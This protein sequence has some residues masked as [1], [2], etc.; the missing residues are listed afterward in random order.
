VNL[1]PRLRNRLGGFRRLAGV[2]TSATLLA[3]LA[4]SSFAAATI[5]IINIDGPGEGFNDATA[6]APVGGNPGVTIGQQRLLCF[7]Q[8]ATIWGATLTSSVTIQI[9]AA[10]N[11][12][13]CTATSAVLGSAGPRFVEFGAPGLEF[14][15]VWYHEALACKEAGVD[16]T[17]AGD[18]G[19]PPGDDGSDINA[20]FNSNLGN[21]GCLTGSGWY[22]GFD[23]NEGAK[24]DLLAV[25]EHEF[26]HGLGFSTVTSGTTGNYLN[27]P[28]ALPALWDKYLFDE[29]TGLHWD[30]NTAAQR[31]ASA[32]NTGNLTWDGPSVTTS[33]GTFLAHSP[34]LVVPYAPGTVVVNTAAFG[35]ALTIAGVT[36][37][38]VVVVD[39]VAPTG[40]GCDTPF[41]NA[42]A[43]AGKIAVIDRGTCTFV[44]KVKNA[45]DAGA[46]GCI[47]VNNAAGAL[48]P[49]GADPTITIPTVGITLADGN[50]LKAAITGGPTTVTMRLNPTLL[51]GAHPSGRVR[52]FSPNP[53]QSGSSVSH[54]DVSLTPNALM[55]PAINADLSGTLDLTV[56]LFRDIGWFGRGGPVAT[57]LALV[58][59]DVVNGHP[60]LEWFSADGANETMRLYR[61]AL[62]ADFER[63]GELSANGTGMV[64]YDDMDVLPG[65]G[66]D[67]KLGLQ[68]PTGERMLGFAHV[69]VPFG[70]QLA[71][72]RLAGNAAGGALAFA[73]VLT[74]DVPAT[75]DLMD[76][77][78]R[79]IARQDLGGLGAGEH[80]VSLTGAPSSGVYWARVSQAGQSASTHF[81]LVQ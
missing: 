60:H 74:K 6:A 24:I 57:Q 45:Q 31:V 68:T 7:Q 55:E 26:G 19:L 39:P 48:A 71:I 21:V 59:A 23:H 56:D 46:I 76:A 25:L 75:L 67:Y 17:P 65:R 66:Y 2:L 79:R 78:G 1:R 38:A 40:D 30:Q 18:P 81:V 28:P 12:L 4:S 73:V 9:R 64:R 49:G 10:F 69:D 22:Y 34:E 47:L 14:A 43:L 51:A 8:A 11:P 3:A 15:N 27:G 36:A 52:M 42:G 62:P 63:V 5:T 20:Q 80:T 58:A 37:E 32:I 61:A 13:S 70:G 33:A 41:A 77:A 50:T 72:K 16:L 29:T 44:I 53:F 35:G 54:Y